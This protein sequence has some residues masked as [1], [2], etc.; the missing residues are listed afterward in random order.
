MKIANH[1]K[2]RKSDFQGYHINNQMYKFQHSTKKNSRYTKE[3]ESI[4]RSK[5]NINQ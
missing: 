1:G 4:V 5:E 2:R 3:Q